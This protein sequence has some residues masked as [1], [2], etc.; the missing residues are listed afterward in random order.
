M[1]LYF[2]CTNDKVEK[3]AIRN[4]QPERIL[5]SYHY[6]KKA[7]LKRI[8][9]ELGYQP[10]IMLDSGA[11]SYWTKGKNVSIIDYMKYIKEN[12]EYITEYMALDV[13][14][15]PNIS[16]KYYEIMKMEGFNPIP[17]YHYGDDE[18][19]LQRYVDDGN[20]YIALGKTVPIKNKNV[21]KNWVNDLIEKY[22]NVKFHLLGSSGK[23]ITRNTRIH[24]V[25]A[26]TWIRRAIIGFPRHIQG[27]DRDT[28]RLRA[29]WQ[30][31]EITRR[32]KEESYVAQDE[33][34]LP[35]E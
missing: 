2:V 25:D 16:I 9:E 20:T 1:D 34:I 17:V 19:Y 15:N 21:V 14:D 10:K 35:E 31:R 26:S 18:S 13:M 6:L 23:I 24:S 3:E 27:T 28:K 30:I 22:P 32:V 11:F 8:V 29:E 5:M 12:E 33:E 4:V 7:P